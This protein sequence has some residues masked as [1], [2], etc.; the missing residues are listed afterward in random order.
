MQAL[1]RSSVIF[2]SS[3]HYQEVFLVEMEN[4]RFMWSDVIPPQYLR[5]TLPFQG[6]IQFLGVEKDLL[7]ELLPHLCHIMG[8]L[9][10][11]GGGPHYS[12]CPET[13]QGIVKIYRLPYPT[14]HHS[15][16]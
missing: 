3:E 14:I 13:I 1:E 5:A 10:F 9:D 4:P 6:V 7:E 15:R 16:H 12:T 11:K 2:P 8:Q